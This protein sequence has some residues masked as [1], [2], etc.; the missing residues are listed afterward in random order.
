MMTNVDCAV[1]CKKRATALT[2]EEV[3]VEGFDG[4]SGHW[5]CATANE[6]AVDSAVAASLG[7][8]DDGDEV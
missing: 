7:D 8:L 4:G 1:P 3:E 5:I 6:R 2:A